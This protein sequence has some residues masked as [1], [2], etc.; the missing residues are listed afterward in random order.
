MPRVI[1]AVVMANKATIRECDEYYSAEDL[2]DMLEIIVVDAANKQT[3]QKFYE[4][5]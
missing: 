2:Y 1:A 3:I 5:K 4:G